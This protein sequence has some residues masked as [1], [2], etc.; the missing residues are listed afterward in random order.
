MPLRVLSRHVRPVRIL[1][2]SLA[3][4]EV[5]HGR[6]NLFMADDDRDLLDRH[7]AVQEPGDQR[8]AESVRM[9]ILHIRRCGH[10]AEHIPDAAGADTVSGSV[11]EQSLTGIGS[12][13]QVFLQRHSRDVVQKDGSFLVSFTQDNALQL[14]KV[15]VV[16]VQANDLPDAAAGGQQERDDGVIPE[17]FIGVLPDQFNIRIGKR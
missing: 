12:G 2:P 7:P 5:F 1:D 6:I 17:A 15:D 11:D 16:P 4:T 10:F 9:N 8:T 3:G 14:I 13:E